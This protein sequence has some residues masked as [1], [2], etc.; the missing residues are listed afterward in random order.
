MHD[1][2]PMACKL[3]AGELS[4]RLAQIR[5]LG[6][7]ALLGVGVDGSLRFRPGE[8]T[9]RRL[10]A[11]VAAESLCCPFLSFDLRDCE[12][13]IILSVGAPEGG[14]ALARELR[15]AFAGAEWR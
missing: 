2:I 5:A 15:D 13:A 11:I 4:G 9:H 6:R 8:A 3:S 10:E 12:G 14:E 7:D 1:E